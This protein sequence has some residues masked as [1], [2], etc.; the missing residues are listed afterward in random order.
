LENTHPTK[1]TSP[2]ILYSQQVAESAPPVPHSEFPLWAKPFFIRPVGD[3]ASA[4][5][6]REWRGR[7][8]AHLEPRGEAWV[9]GG[10]LQLRPESTLY[11]PNYPK[12]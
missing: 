4:G 8:V 5:R 3:P 10:K 1:K 9:K 7:L 6:L 2:N 11:S 12:A